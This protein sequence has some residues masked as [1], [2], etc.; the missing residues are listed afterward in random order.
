MMGAGLTVSELNQV[1]SDSIRREPGL[2][3]VLVTGEIGS[4]KHHLPS[5]HWYFTLKDAKASI[6]CVMFHQNT[7]NASLRP[8]D[9]DR[10]TLLGYVEMYARDGKVQLYA[11]RMKPAGLGSL[12]EQLETL[13]RKLSAEGQFDPGRKRMLPLLPRKVALVTSSSGAAL[14]DMLNVSGLRCPG[15]PIVIV[16]GAVQGADAPAELIAALHRAEGLPE[17]DVIILARGGGSQEDLWCFND[18]GLARAV[19]GCSVPVVTGIGHET[20]TTLVDYVADVRASTPSNAAEI[21]FPD[22]ADLAERIRLLGAGLTRAV[23]SQTDGGLIRIHLQRDRLRAVSPENQLHRLTEQARQVRRELTGAVSLL[24]RDAEA[25]L[26]QN[27]SELC[28]AAGRDAQERSAELERFRAALTF[29]AERRLRDAEASL[30]EAETRLR[31]ISPLAVL[32]RGYALVYDPE[33]KVIPDA[34]AAEKASE[35]RVR[36]RDGQVEVERKERT[37]AHGKAFL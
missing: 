8:R 13:K 3:N 17:V 23:K 4:F 20:D 37:K 16:P 35:M 5:G 21:V 24:L 25:I 1:I 34:K 28:F 36:F 27:R 15:V 22:R 10:V 29:R 9:G 6:S 14:Q 31:A 2:R 12:Y 30:A 11:L 7:V 32:E 19:A 33:G 18:E 26:G